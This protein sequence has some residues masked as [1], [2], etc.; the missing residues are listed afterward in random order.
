M[1]KERNIIALH[2]VT[3]TGSKERTEERDERPSLEAK[4]KTKS[5]C[6]KVYRRIR[7]LLF[8]RIEECDWCVL[9]QN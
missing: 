1:R 3:D 2:R 8:E 7:L 4:V 6:C 5:H 9:C